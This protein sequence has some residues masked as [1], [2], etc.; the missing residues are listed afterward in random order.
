[1]IRTTG[2]ALAGLVLAS[3]AAVGFAQDSDPQAKFQQDYEKKVAQ[4]WFTDN[5]FTD[6]YD[7]ALERAKEAGKPVFA[8]FT[9]SYSP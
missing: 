5:G 7:V 9:R 3:A 6:D 1:M 2:I 8:Y 4:S